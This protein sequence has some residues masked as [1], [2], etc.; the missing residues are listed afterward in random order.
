VIQQTAPATGRL[1]PQTGP[2][3]ILAAEPVVGAGELQAPAGTVAAAGT[4]PSIGDVQPAAYLQGTAF[5]T[6]AADA[7]TAI[8]RRS[9]EAALRTAGLF[10]RFGKKIAGPF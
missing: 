8:G 2:R 10:T 1:E 6:T 9:Q 7:G 5:W 3:D 4:E